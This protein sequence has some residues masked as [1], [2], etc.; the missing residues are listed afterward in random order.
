MMSEG[1]AKA[2]RPEAIKRAACRALTTRRAECR[3]ILIFPS[4]D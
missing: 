3:V 1:M 4:R 2:T